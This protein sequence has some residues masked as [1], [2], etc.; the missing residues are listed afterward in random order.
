M[1]KAL[2]NA[3]NAQLS[4]GPT[5]PEGKS[6][7]SQNALRHGLTARH[8]IV[9]EDQ[10]QQFDELHNALLEEIDPQGAMENFTFHQL[11]HA[12]WNL[13]RFRALE[14]D[15]MVNGLDPILD[16]SAA[17][18]LDRLQRY[19]ARA[20]RSYYRALKE[21]RTLQTD[22]AL[23]DVKLDEEL[24]EA[25]PALVSINDLTKQTHSEVEAEAIRIANDLLGY[26]ANTF[27]RQARAE[28][29]RKSAPPAA[30]AA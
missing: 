26:E 9:R 27:Y 25:C 8:L 30:P 6:R 19:A 29:A 15:L 23:R 21:L 22:R 5:T 3:A 18:T 14:A 13:E 10:R 4:T 20:E 12:A 17:K 1:A 16:D 24:A 7:S 28:R 11:V 2:A